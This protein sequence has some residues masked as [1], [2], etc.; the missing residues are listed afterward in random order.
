MAP[1]CQIH[2][3]SLIQNVSHAKVLAEHSQQVEHCVNYSFGT[4]LRSSGELLRRSLKASI[5]PQAEQR[6]NQIATARVRQ[7]VTRN[8]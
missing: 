5:Q 8:A 6:C 4:L 1:V 3:G 7:G 2:A